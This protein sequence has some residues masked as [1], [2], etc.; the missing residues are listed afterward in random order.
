MDNDQDRSD[1]SAPPDATLDA[2]LAQ[3]R[4][5]RP[6]SPMRK[7][8]VWRA[9]QASQRAT[10][11]TSSTRR[12]MAAAAMVV[13]AGGAGL[14]VEWTRRVEGSGGQGSAVVDPVLVSAGPILRALTTP[15]VPTPPVAE[16][17][18]SPSVALVKEDTLRRQ[19]A[20]LLVA[21]RVAM[22]DTSLTSQQERLLLDVEYVL[23]QVVEAGSHDQAE[24]ALIRN[25]INSR[26]LLRR[27]E[28]GG[29]Q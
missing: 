1:F 5:M 10:S 16:A 11:E 29:L 18:A 27:V 12:W 3:L 20:L 24:G 8:E 25:T 6:D 21:T 9:I 2:A 22:D 13:M 28:R 19:S 26:N 17:A 15:Q 7:D 14:A 23:A 4:G